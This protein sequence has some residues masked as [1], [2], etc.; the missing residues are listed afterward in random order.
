M[1]SAITKKTYKI[2]LVQ[3]KENII[4]FLPKTVIMSKN[5]LMAKNI[6]ENELL[7]LLILMETLFIFRFHIRELNFSYILT[8]LGYR[9]QPT[10]FS[11]IKMAKIYSRKYK[12]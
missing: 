12:K 4:L 5:L 9:F 7:D 10:N 11:E 8:Y 6:S 3:A 2:T 1:L